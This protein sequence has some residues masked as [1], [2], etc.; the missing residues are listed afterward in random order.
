MP[1]AVTRGYVP[2]APKHCSLKQRRLLS[3]SL[4]GRLWLKVQ[5][6][7]GWALAIVA[8]QDVAGR[9]PREEARVSG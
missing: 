8:Q 2:K 3:H 6:P 5:L 7:H 1:A 9:I 4:T